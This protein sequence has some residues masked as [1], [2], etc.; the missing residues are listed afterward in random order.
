[1]I[2]LPPDV[3]GGVAV[4]HFLLDQLGEGPRDARAPGGSRPA[5]PAANVPASPT[6]HP[7]GRTS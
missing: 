1:M 5:E 7:K 3:R 2:V 4:L 6:A